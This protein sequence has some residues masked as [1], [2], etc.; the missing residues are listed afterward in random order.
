MQELIGK[1]P[2]VQLSHL[3][4]PEGVNLFA[5]L[6]LFNPGGSV[7]DRTG[8]YMIEDAERKGLLKPGGTIVEG[9]AGNTGI[10][11]AFAALN[12]GYRVIFVVPLKF[13]VENY[14][15]KLFF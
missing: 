13:S 5:K 15:L 7:K 12:R 3:D 10:G 1:T 9:T 14:K 11:I 6:E 2:L 8:K 4:L